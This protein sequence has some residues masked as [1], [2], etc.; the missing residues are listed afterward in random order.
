MNEW[1][2][3]NDRLPPEPENRTGPSS[4]KTVLFLTDHGKIT[5]GY[6]C[7]NNRYFLDNQV[8]AW[9]KRNITH[10]MPLPDPPKKTKGL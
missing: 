1:I 7:G 2:D 5:T 3:I 6:Y 4:V 10:W 9:N 8:F